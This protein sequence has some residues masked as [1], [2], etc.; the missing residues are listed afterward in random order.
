M[1]LLDEA[2]PEILIASLSAPLE[3]PVRTAFRQ[4]ATEAIG[5]KASPVQV[6]IG[7]PS[8]PC[9]VFSSARRLISAP[10]TML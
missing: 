3:S 5:R 7:A 10:A 2:D 4:A 6:S 8:H 1:S 9:N